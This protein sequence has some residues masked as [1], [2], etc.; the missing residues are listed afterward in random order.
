M[1]KQTFAIYTSKLHVIIQ[2]TAQ[3]SLSKKNVLRYS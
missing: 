1:V 2:L 3:W